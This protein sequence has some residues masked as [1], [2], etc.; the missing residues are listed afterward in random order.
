[1]T[2]TGA[3]E[4]GKRARLEGSRLPEG[5][6]RRHRGYRRERPEGRP[7]KRSPGAWVK[8]GKDHRG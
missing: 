4:E 8:N 6:I 5:G 1:M 3:I 7:G 2:H